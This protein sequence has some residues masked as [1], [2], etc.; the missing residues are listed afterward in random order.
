MKP[1]DALPGPAAPQPS[2]T[3]HGFFMNSPLRGAN[4]N[5]ERVADYPRVG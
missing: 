3:V 2:Q 5:L 1:L 4:L